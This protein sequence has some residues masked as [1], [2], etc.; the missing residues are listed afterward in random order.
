MDKFHLIVLQ[1]N[2]E[3]LGYFSSMTGVGG[4]PELVVIGSNSLDGPWEVNCSTPFML[5]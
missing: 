4:R 2:A 1:F 3:L 5:I